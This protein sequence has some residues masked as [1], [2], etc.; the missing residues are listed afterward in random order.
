MHSRIASRNK[1]VLLGML[2]LVCLL[3]LLPQKAVATEGSDLVTSS[4]ANDWV[5]AGYSKLQ[6]PLRLKIERTDG[7]GATAPEFAASFY[8]KETGEWV[9]A[10]V[11]NGVIRS[12]LADVRNMPI[13]DLPSTGGSGTLPFTIALLCCVGVVVVCAWRLRRCRE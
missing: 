12:G 3:H 8:N 4:A 7:S 11:E 10:A 13:G 6:E 2:V 1:L 9:P 5:P